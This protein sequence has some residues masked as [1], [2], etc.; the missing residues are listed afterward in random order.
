MKMYYADSDL[1]SILLAIITMAA[2]IYSSTRKRKRVEDIPAHNPFVEEEVPQEE[3][4][5]EEIYQEPEQPVQNQPEAVQQIP[6]QQEPEKVVAEPQKTVCKEEKQKDFK[7]R[8]K[9]SPKDA[10]L[11]SEILKPKYKEF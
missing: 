4:P 2:G 7:S 8:L 1:I 9:S 11:F 5:L 3:V 6:V 10:V